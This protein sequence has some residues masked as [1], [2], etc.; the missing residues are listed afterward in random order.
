MR[1]ISNSTTGLC[2]V[3]ACL[4]QNASATSTLQNPCTVQK[5]E[6]T[7]ILGSNFD[8]SSFFVCELQGADSELVAGGVSGSQLTVEINQVDADMILS[9]MDHDDL[10]GMTIYTPGLT[11]DANHILSFPD[12]VVEIEFGVEA[13]S[14]GGRRLGDREG[15]H[16]VLMVRVIASNKALEHSADVLSDKAFGTNGDP[17]NLSE[18]FQSCSYGQLL[19]EPTDNAMATNGVVEI[20]IDLE[21]TYAET[22]SEDVTNAVKTKLGAMVGGNDINIKDTFRHVIMCI[23]S[24]TA[25]KG[26]PGW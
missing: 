24:G 1:F 2:V 22:T 18:R 6:V 19:M 10:D 25:L 13:E 21:I 15:S 20:E 23:P 4:L 26:N 8:D 14:P 11:I 7:P 3:A 12:G 16:S 9:Q 17:I 5:I